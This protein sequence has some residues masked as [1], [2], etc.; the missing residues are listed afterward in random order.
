MLP[1]AVVVYC[2][3]CVKPKLYHNGGGGFVS[4]HGWWIVT[5]ANAPWMQNNIVDVDM[6]QT[7]VD[8]H[9]GFGQ[10]VTLD[11]GCLWLLF[12]PMAAQR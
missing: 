9:V 4:A 1:V 7:P 10:F 12:V 11:R 6:H 2:T 3:T 8:M 5:I